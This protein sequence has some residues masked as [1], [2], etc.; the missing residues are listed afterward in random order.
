MKQYIFKPHVYEPPFSPY[1]DSYKDHKF[2]ISG[3][4]PQTSDH[5]YL[6]CIDDPSIKVNGC[7]DMEDLEEYE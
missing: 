2:I 5:V 3:T 1:Y 4:H 7:V 6:K